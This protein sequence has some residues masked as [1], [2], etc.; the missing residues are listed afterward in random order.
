M[1]FIS[2]I[3]INIIVIDT[4]Y[5]SNH[6]T[7]SI[8]IYVNMMMIAITVIIRT[9]IINSQSIHWKIR[10]ELVKYIICNTVF[11][12]ITIIVNVE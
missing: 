3:V 5:S 7:A 8:D 11:T 1:F 2:I 9:S 10:T 4:S 6:D 12:I